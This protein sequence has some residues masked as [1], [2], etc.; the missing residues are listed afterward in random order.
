MKAFYL[1]YQILVYNNVSLNKLI[2]LKKINLCKWNL[3]RYLSHSI[4]SF[5]LKWSHK[6]PGL[7]YIQEFMVIE[8]D[9][10]IDSFSSLVRK[11]S[12]NYLGNR[13]QC[14]RFVKC[15][16]TLLQVFI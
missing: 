5:L 3:P 2:F 4:L 11:S 7:N 15:F 16:D 1:E 9:E 6:N 8:V 13:F 10:F 14:S 12:G